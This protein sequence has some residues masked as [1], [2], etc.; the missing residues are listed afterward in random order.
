MAWEKFQE[1]IK[2]QVSVGD[3]INW[4]AESRSAGE[5]LKIVDVPFEPG[6]SSKRY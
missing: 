5:L 1:P 2:Q 4:A 3:D 6:T